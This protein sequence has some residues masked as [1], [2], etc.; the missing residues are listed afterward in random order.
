M[1]RASGDV[2][3]DAVRARSGS[4]GRF[5]HVGVVVTITGTPMVLDV[6]PFGTG[7]AG[8]H[9]IAAFVDEQATVR[10]LVMRPRQPVVV[11]KLDRYAADIVRRRVSFDYAFDANDDSRLYC[12][13]LVYKALR[14]AGVSWADVQTQRMNVLLTGD[15]DVITPDALAH[16][17]ALTS[18]AGSGS[19]TPPWLPR[20]TPRLECSVRV[21][22]VK[23]PL[24]QTPPRPICLGLRLRRPP[25][26]LGFLLHR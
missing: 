6:S 14:K 1:F 3:S 24:R 7:H 2:I 8:L 10:V 17:V 22:L 4:A 21:E 13:E 19:V 18:V 9:T 25:L 23:W 12:S 11:R 26:L 15:R 20:N 16:S 5:S